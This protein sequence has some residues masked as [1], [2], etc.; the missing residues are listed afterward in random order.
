MGPRDSLAIFKKRQ[1]S[2]PYKE[3]R[4]GPSSPQSSLYSDGGVVSWLLNHVRYV[5]TV[6]IFITELLQ[7]RSTVQ[8]FN[9]CKPQFHNLPFCISGANIKFYEIRKHSRLCFAPHLPLTTFKNN[10]FHTSVPN[11]SLHLRLIALLF[12]PTHTP[13]LTLFSNNELAEHSSYVLLIQ[14]LQRN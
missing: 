7:L 2:Y 1:L 6:R 14:Q 10:F 8:L 4:C 11:T 3:S 5:S 9:P 12:H 13:T